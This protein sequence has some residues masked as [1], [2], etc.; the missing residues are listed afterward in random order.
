LIKTAHDI[1]DGGIT[2]ALA[3]A[4]MT[5]GL[6]AKCNFSFCDNRIDKVLFGEG[7]SR[8]IISVASDKL[9]S[10]MNFVEKINNNFLEPVAITSIGIVNKLETLEIN[11]DDK[12]IINLSINQIASTYEQAIQNRIESSILEND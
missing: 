7:G 8:V 1:S 10:F 9:D 6:G 11:I 3:E 12:Q 4:S 5:S 2:I